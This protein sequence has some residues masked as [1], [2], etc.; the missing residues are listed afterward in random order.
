M[1]D[2][3]YNVEVFKRK[4][5]YTVSIPSAVSIFDLP[6]AARAGFW[7][8]QQISGTTIN[9]E[10]V[11]ISNSIVIYSTF[12]TNCTILHCTALL[13]TYLFCTVLHCNFLWCTAYTVMHWNTLYYTILHCNI[14]ECTVLICN[15]LFFTAIHSTVLYCNSLNC[16][17]SFCTATLH[18]NVL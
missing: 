10:N 2:V 3:P 13:C 18:G 8:L 9:P 11:Y 14:L 1:Y 15:E 4:H 17:E 16:A 5:F 12:C 7:L 6:G